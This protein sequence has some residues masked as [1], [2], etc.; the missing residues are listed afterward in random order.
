MAAIPT[1]TDVILQQSLMMLERMEADEIGELAVKIE[2]MQ[3]QGL[4]PKIF[5][6]HMWAMEKAVVWTR[7]VI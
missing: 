5:L 2:D 3:Y 1:V 7:K 4:V 6:A